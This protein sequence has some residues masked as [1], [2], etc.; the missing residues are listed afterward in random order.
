MKISFD[1]LRRNIA[2]DFN[3]LVV[4]I[5]SEDKKLGQGACLNLDDEVNRLRQSIGCLLACHDT[6]QQPDDFNDLSDVELKEL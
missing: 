5:I 3:A 4:E 1:G 2:N 6:H